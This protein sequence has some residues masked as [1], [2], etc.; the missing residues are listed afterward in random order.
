MLRAL[1]QSAS[2]S[3]RKLEQGAVAADF[4][5]P[6][7]KSRA[8]TPSTPL[9]GYEI[10]EITIGP[11]SPALGRGVGEIDWPPGSLVVAVTA[12]QEIVPVHNDTELRAGERVILLAPAASPPVE[13]GETATQSEG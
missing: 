9:S 7:P 11:A 1:A 12:G 2:S 4:A 6:D 8:P 13:A 10:V 3:E 5:V